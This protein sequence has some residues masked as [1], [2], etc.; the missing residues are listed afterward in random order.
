MANS[1]RLL[2]QSCLI[3]LLIINSA[4]AAP[5]PGSHVKVYV[6]SLPYLYVSHA[7]NGALLKPANNSR[8][9]DYDLA[10]SYRQLSDTEY[11]FSLRQGVVFQDGSRFDADAVLENMRYFKKAPFLFSKFHEY[12]DRTEKVDDYTVRFHLK[13]KYGSFIN[14]V[15]WLHFY[16]TDYLKKFGWNGKA[17]CPNLA[18]PGPYATGPYILK[19]GYIEGDRNTP[20]AV[21]VANP[22]YY[23]KDLVKVETITVYTQLDS[24]IALEEVT[25]SEGQLDIMPIPVTE[26]ASVMTSAYSKLISGPSNDNIAIHI[27]MI[28]GNPKLKDKKIRKALN[29]A[30]NQQAIIKNSFFGFAES[31]PTLASPNFPGVNQVAKSL[32]AYSDVQSPKSIRQE[33]TNTLNGLKLKVLTQERFMFLWKS[34]DRDLRKVGV[35]LEFKITQNETVIFE[36]LLSTNAGKNTMEWDLLVWGDDDWYFNHPWSAFFVYKTDSV[37]STISP[38]PTMNAYIDTML[39]ETLNTDA[40]TQIIRKIMKRAYDNAYMLFVPAPKKVMAVNQ[41]VNFTPYKM[42]TIPLWEVE[43]TDQHWSVK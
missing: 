4:K 18:E 17:T 16:T 30:L 12:Y 7:I 5:T 14:D 34:I 37:W 43:V 42:A 20:K 26:V 19:E 35:E 13:A 39:T 41:E 33:L 31:K 11:E 24:D 22:N 6:P 21:L 2:M 29:Q 36:Q 32:K 3:T 23:D 40:S 25:D 9:W 10:T 38:D 1:L 27:N 28:T 15:I 8:S